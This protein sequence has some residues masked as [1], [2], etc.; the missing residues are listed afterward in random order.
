MAIFTN[1]A[2]LTYNGVTVNS[3]VASGEIIDEL[4]I[5]KTSSADSYT[6]GDSIPYVISLINSGDTAINGL[7]VT[8]NLGAYSYTPTGGTETTLYPLTYV[9]GSALYYINGVLQPAVT[10]NATAD[11]VEFTGISV[12]ANG[13]TTIVYQTTVNNFAPLGTDT[14][15]TLSRTITNT[16]TVNGYNIS[17]TETID[18]SDEPILAVNKSISPVPVTDNGTVT[19][20]FDIQNF[21]N[22]A[23][24]DDVVLSDIFELPLTITSVTYNGTPWTEETEYTFTNN[25]FTSTAGAITVPAATFTQNANGTWTAIP[26]TSTLIITGIVTN[27]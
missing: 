21:G 4:S 14:A 2:Q 12:P 19:Y 6:Q 15:T 1:Q 7:T 5:T 20:T 25:T 18:A 3:N 8:D 17:D 22:S 27:A 11:S 26:S 13:N 10:V 23:S 24:G 9:T 16:A